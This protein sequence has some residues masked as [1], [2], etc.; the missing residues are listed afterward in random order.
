VNLSGTETR[1]ELSIT[2][3]DVTKIRRS[4]RNPNKLLLLLLGALASISG[5]F[6][7]YFLDMEN[8]LGYPYASLGLSVSAVPLKR[9]GRW[10]APIV[11]IVAGLVSFVLGAVVAD[12]PNYG[13]TP[14]YSVCRM[15]QPVDS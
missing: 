15:R 14:E 12:P 7:G 9:K 6:L 11:M 13:L 1:E 3:E 5:F 10:L 2:D 8:R 4:K